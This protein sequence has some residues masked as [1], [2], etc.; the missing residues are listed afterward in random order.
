MTDKQ[1]RAINVASGALIAVG[2]GGFL[3]TGGT[4]DAA[5]NIVLGA[6]ALVNAGVALFN[7][8]KS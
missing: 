8:I 3:L 6:I 2:T 7:M 1:K 4:G 5:G